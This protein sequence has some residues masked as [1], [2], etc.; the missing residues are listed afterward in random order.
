MICPHCQ[1]TDNK[2]IDSRTTKEGKAIRRRRECSKCGH[3]YTTY[4]YVE[5]ARMVVKNNGTKEPYDEGKLLAGLYSACKKR[6]ISKAKIQELMEQIENAI[7][8][9][10]SD[11]PDEIPSMFIG[12]MVMKGLATLDEV[13]YMRFASVYQNFKEGSE[14]ITAM[15]G[16]SSPKQTIQ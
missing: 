9:Y 16:I 11:P 10:K 2:V 13:A 3:R 6:P 5:M 15:D 7:S 4:E 1:C 14:F 12:E 8:K